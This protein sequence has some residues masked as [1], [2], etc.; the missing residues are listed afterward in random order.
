[1]SP[2]FRLYFAFFSAVVILIGLYIYQE[3]KRKEQYKLPDDEFKKI[4][5]VPISVNCPFC[6]GGKIDARSPISMLG[7]I[8]ILLGLLFTPFF[9]LGLLLILFGIFAREK[10][11]YCVNCDRQF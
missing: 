4:K 8:L 10:K 6:K 1:M 7:W 2:L 5:K 3:M 9:G 11:Y